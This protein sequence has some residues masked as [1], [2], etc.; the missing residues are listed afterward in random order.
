MQFTLDDLKQIE[1]YFEKKGIKDSQFDSLFPPFTGEEHCAIVSNGKN[2]KIKLKDIL[3]LFN[4]DDTLSPD[5][6]NPV[7]NKV[8]YNTIQDIQEQIKYIIENCCKPS[9]I[10]SII[11]EYL[12]IYKDSLIKSNTLYINNIKQSNI[13]GNS[14]VFINN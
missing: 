2:R 5:S 6:T 11:E 4:V 10:A 3:T 1:S 9:M 12:Y 13:N 8:I 14:L 7:E